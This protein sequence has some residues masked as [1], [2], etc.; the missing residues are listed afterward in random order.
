MRKIKQ[1]SPLAILFITI[2]FSCNKEDD[3]IIV[4]PP[5][6]RSEEAAPATL[7]IEKYL[8]THFYNYEEFEN[9]SADFNYRVVFDTIAGENAS[10][11]PLTDQVTFKNVDDIFADGVTYKMYYLNVRQG[12]GDRIEFTDNATVNYVGTSLRELEVL[13]DEDI[14][15]NGA[16]DDYVTVYPTN[17][18]DSTVSPIPFDLTR[19]VKGMQAVMIEFNGATGFT[20]NPDGTLTFDNYGIGAVFMQSGLGYYNIPPTGS[21][22][23]YYDQLIFTFQTF[24]REKSDQDL[25]TIL[26]SFE[27]LNGNGNELDDDTDSDG[28]PNFNDPDDDGDGRLTKYEVEANEYILNPGDPDPEFEANEVEMQRKTDDETG[29]VTLTTV[30]FTDVNNDG[31]PDYLDENL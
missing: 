19:V 20:E 5:R 17:V 1:F 31:V 12:E 16:L 21:S 30:V 28:F 4:V 22:I 29:I 27:D 9:P 15:G 8:D 14:D 24:S 23:E 2:L 3:G 18:F 26:S 13:S 7:M 10:K 11:I 6:E 25:D